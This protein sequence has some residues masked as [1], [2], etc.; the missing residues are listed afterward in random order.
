MSYNS[1]NHKNCHLVNAAR[2]IKYAMVVKSR[3]LWMKTINNCMFEKALLFG[4]IQM[5]IYVRRGSSSSSIPIICECVH[6]GEYSQDVLCKQTTTVQRDVPV[7]ERSWKGYPHYTHFIDG[8][9]WYPIFCSINTS[10]WLINYAQCVPQNNTVN[11]NVCVC[12]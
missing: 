7:Q 11:W 9:K 4:N 3:P 5:Y 12:A 1:F 10:I 6:A 2:P 8:Q